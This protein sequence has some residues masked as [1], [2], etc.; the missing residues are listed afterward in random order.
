MEDLQNETIPQVHALVD[1]TIEQ[2]FGSILDD[3]NNLNFGGLTFASTYIG[4]VNSLSTITDANLST[5][6]RTYEAL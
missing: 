5:T 4:Y 6:I 1:L 2:H 3:M